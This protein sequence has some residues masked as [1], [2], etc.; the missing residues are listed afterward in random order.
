[1]KILSFKQKLGVL[2]VLVALIGAAAF[3]STQ[4]NSG[5]RSDVFNNPAFVC[6]D[7][8]LTSQ[9]TSY[10]QNVATIQNKKKER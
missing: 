10:D 2:S 6:S 8:T 1:M 9:K 4:S 3:M 7:D 5:L